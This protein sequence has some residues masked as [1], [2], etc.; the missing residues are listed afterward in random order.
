[1]NGLKRYLSFL[2]VLAVFAGCSKPSTDE[3]LLRAIVKDTVS[4]A[5]D[6]DVKG[7]MGHIS[8]AFN[9]DHGNDYNAAKGLLLYEFMRSEKVSVFIRD[10]AVEV[11]GDRAL[12]DARVILV[13]GR[14]V[15]NLSDVVPDEASGFKFSVVFRKEE[16]QWKALSAK[17]DDVGALGLL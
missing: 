8:K 12:V 15:K 11:K 6:K 9:D 7:V 3:E 5:K 2:I 1:M 14:E 4:A 16:G 10:V 17:W 13:R